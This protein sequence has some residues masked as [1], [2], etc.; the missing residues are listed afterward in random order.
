MRGIPF[1]RHKLPPIS[2]VYG[3]TAQAESGE[4]LRPRLAATGEYIR[5]IGGRHAEVAGNL[6]LR[7]AGR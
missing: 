1:I 6:A 2:S 7:S 4:E 3:F 5:E